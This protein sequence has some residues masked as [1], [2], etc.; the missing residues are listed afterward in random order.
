[1]L[2]RRWPEVDRIQL[3]D[4]YNV[5]GHAFNDAF[6]LVADDLI[7]GCQIIDRNWRYAYVNNAVLS[8]GR[9]SREELLGRTMMETYPGIENTHMFSMLRRCMEERV[10]QTLENEFIYPDGSKGWFELRFNPVPE[11]VFILSL[12]ISERKR[13]ETSL[14]YMN[15]VL[16]GVRA[17]NQLIIRE[18]DPEILIRSACDCLVSARGFH[19]VLIAL[20]NDDASLGNQACA[21]AELPILSAAIDRGDFPESAR[22]AMAQ[23]DKVIRFSKGGDDDDSFSEIT[24]VEDEDVLCLGLHHEKHCYG[25]MFAF[26]PAGIGADVEEHGL[27]QEAGGDIAFA[28]HGIRVQEDSRRVNEELRDVE[29]QLRQ[30]Q[31]LEAIGQLAGGVAHDFNNLLMVQMGYCDLILESLSPD[32]PLAADL[33]QILACSERAAGLTRQLLAFGRKQA[34]QPEILDLNEV[35][36]RVHTLLRRLIGEDI[37]LV[38]EPGEDLDRVMADPGQIEQVIMN[39]ALNARDAMPQ[40]GKLTIETANVEL[41]ENFSRTHMNLEPGAYVMLAVSDSGSG[42][43]K[44]TLARLFEPF[45]TTKEKGKGTGLGLA[46]VYGIVKQSGGTIWV[47]SELGEGTI[48]KVYLPRVEARSV[49]ATPHRE[50][51]VQG[52]G[53]LVLV[54]EDDPALR[55]LFERI[56]KALGFCVKI[57]ANGEEAL[58]LVRVEGLR[59]DLLITDVVMPG[60]AGSVL[61]EKLTEHQPG[62]KVLYTSG[63]TDSA[64]VHHGVLRADTPFIQKPFSRRVLGNKI[65]D[66]LDMR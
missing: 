29:Q 53:E 51:S 16:R 59:P 10:V 57:A 32:D 14:A 37:D 26:V 38:T 22:A 33:T 44:R 3:P 17:V 61:A 7:E 30:S 54:V 34:M 31:K 11:G 24:L 15:A 62:L 13:A 52:A 39:L 8:Q 42:M 65:R 28:L 55:K 63:Y 12:D 43:D 46:T 48:F 47:Y 50:E 58:T 66:V 36:T 4:D 5:T 49:T 18:K 25:F 56:V 40:G 20:V 21:G 64:V 35:L 19:A 9:R 60:M 27:L 45:F 1:M 23:S 2:R 6:S 41:D